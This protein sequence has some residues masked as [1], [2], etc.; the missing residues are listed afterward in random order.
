[1]RRIGIAVPIWTCNTR[2]YLGYLSS[3]GWSSNY[4]IKKLTR[5]SICFTVS[6]GSGY[7]THTFA[8]MGW[9]NSGSY[10]LAYVADNQGNTVHVRNMGQTA[11]TD[12]FAFF[13]N[14]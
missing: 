4:N 13:M 8:F 2:Q 14:K 9:V 12:A 5:G 11:S 7:S 1:M 6:G 3:H 10:T